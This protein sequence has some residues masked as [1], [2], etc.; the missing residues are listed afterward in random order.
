MKIAHFY[1]R[2]DMG[3]AENITL[4][5]IKNDTGNSHIIFVMQ[6]TT[7]F[8]MFCEKKY[9]I[10]FV[11]LYWKSNSFFN[12][13]NWLNLAK[14]L[15]VFKPNLIH[16]Y[17]FNASQL[18]RIFG[19]LFSIPVVTYIVNTYK[20]K[21]FK[22]GLIN[23][24]L[25]FVTDKILVSSQDIKKDVYIFDN[26]PKRM[27]EVV[28]SFA[29]LDFV[30]DFSVDFYMKLG[31]G[32]KDF[33][34]LSIARLVEQKGLFNLVDAIDLSVNI[35]KI[36]NIKLVI[37]GDG[38]L[39]VSL[40][41]K[42]SQLNLEKHISL[43]GQITNLN[44]FLTRANVYVDSSLWAGLN[45]SSIKAI[46]ARLP[47]IISDV[48]GARE[49]TLDGK[50]GLLYNHDD[51]FELTHLIEKVYLGEYK[52]NPKALGFIEK[53]FSDKSAAKTIIDIYTDLAIQ[54]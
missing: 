17:M 34:V 53:N 21:K 6:G 35:H 16:G 38:P 24:I 7:K 32:S 40:R 39:F 43:V 44:P 19:L 50:Y 37:V 13:F 12:L 42:I 15:R 49:L 54:H 52:F 41:D 22:R 11:N 30:S 25:S 9:Q 51:I 45:V 3:G 27:V 28:S 4:A 48:G 10:K 1:Y 20:Y 2:F 8:Q 26:V 47:L 29:I 5:I 31:I 46:E 33:L 36:K 14:K 18:A 23:F